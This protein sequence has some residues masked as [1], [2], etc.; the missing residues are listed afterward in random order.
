MTITRAGHS[1][2]ECGK[3][4][5]DRISRLFGY[6]PDCRR[7]MT[8]AQ[9]T[10]AMRQ[11]AAE[12]AP[13]YIPPDRP[14][15]PQA[16]HNT[17]QARHAATPPR[18]PSPRDEPPAD[19]HAEMAAADAADDTRM[20]PAVC[21]RHGGLVGACPQCRHEA[22]PT[23]AAKRIIAEIK[24]ERRAASDAAYLAYQAAHVEQLTL[25]AS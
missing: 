21:A 7:Q 4:L 10:A 24:A 9:L 23:R 6:G 22:D 18:A 13:G 8:D 12:A 14:A 1:C 20:A 19:I 11:T 2:R 16:R 5:T 3:P 25:D 15:S 17:A